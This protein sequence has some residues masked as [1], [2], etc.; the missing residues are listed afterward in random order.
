MFFDFTR[1]EVVADPYPHYAHYREQDPVH[2]APTANPIFPEQWFLF[3]HA[4]VLAALRDPRLGRDWHRVAPARSAA[5]S[6]PE[7]LRA[8]VEMVDS[9]M[10]FQDPPRHTELRSPLSAAFRPRALAALEPF[11]ADRATALLEKALG[12]GESFDVLADFALPLTS[13][14]IAEVLGVPAAERGRFVEAMRGMEPVFGGSR[15]QLPRAAAAAQEVARLFERVVAADAAER[16]QAIATAILIFGA[17]FAT[18]MHAIANGVLALIRHP[19]ECARLRAGPA[20][21]P[22]AVEEILRFEPPVQRSQR[23]ALEPVEIG[24]VS[25]PRGALIVPVLGAANR[26]PEAFPDPDRFDVGRDAR[27]QVGFGGGIHVCL[28]AWLARLEVRIALAALLRALPRLELAD[29][30]LEWREGAARG[31]RRLALVRA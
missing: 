23:F 25:I 20:L 22:S 27:A 7:P 19:A 26:D 10:L 5:A 3:R 30:R 15:S 12:G 1:P 16:K 24:G 18:T 14:A 11:V 21:L 28:G 2:R 13:G 8:L 4:D 17:G 29:E 9:W 31:V 6:L